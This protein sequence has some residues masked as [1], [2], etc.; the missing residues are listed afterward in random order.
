MQKQV[1]SSSD[2]PQDS[3]VYRVLGDQNFTQQKGFFPIWYRLSSPPDASPEATFGQRERIR[4]ARLASALMLFLGTVLLIA[5]A[6]GASSPNHAIVLVAASMFGAIL[7][8]IPFNRHGHME[9]VG[10]LLILGPIV[11]MYTSIG[12]DA[13]SVGMS[14][15]DKDILYLLFFSD[16]FAGA[17]LPI[18]WVVLVAGI[19]IAFSFLALRFFPHD[20]ALTLLLHTSFSI[21]FPRLVQVHMIASGVIW[22]LVNNLKAALGRADRAEEMVVLQEIERR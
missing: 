16:L 19:N 3:W 8:S 10:F 6:I 13:F 22:I 7:L 4:R 12:V 14:A 11:G 20:P 2:L 18:N 5:G 1:P 15:N 17:L 21:I 9:I